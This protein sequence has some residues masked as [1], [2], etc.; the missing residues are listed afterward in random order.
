MKILLIVFAMSLIISNIFALTPSMRPASEDPLAKACEQKDLQRVDEL[1]KNG[2]NPN[3]VDKISGITPLEAASLAGS[4]EIVRS[5]LKAGADVDQ[6]DLNGENALMAALISEPYSGNEDIALLLILWG[7]DINHKS[8]GGWTAF[9]SAVRW[10]RSKTLLVLKEKGAN[11]N[12]KGW[13]NRTALHMAAWAASP[14][15]IPTLLD[16]GLDVNAQDDEGMTPLMNA[17]S[18]NEMMRNVWSTGKRTPL[19]TVDLLLEKGADCSITN[20]DGKTALDIAKE[21]NAT[22]LVEL[23]KKH[24]KSKN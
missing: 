5:L 24:C 1:L 4:I 12:E 18:H 10:S 16:W 17:V 19:A 20:K 11:I 8:P 9:L 15:T 6:V 22:T 14:V 7:A 3:A 21:G 2:A 13:A 23:I